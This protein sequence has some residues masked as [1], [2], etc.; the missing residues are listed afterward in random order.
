MTMIDWM[1]YEMKQK[2]LKIKKKFQDKNKT[3][4]DSIINQ[5]GI[6]NEK[7]YAQMIL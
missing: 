3:N 7:N 5:D 2:E 4:Q 1:I 6:I